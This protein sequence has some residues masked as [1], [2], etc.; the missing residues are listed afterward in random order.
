MAIEVFNRVEKKFLITKHQ[1]ELLK[2]YL[3]GY[4]EIDDYLKDK[5]TYSI[6]NIYYDTEDE[7]LIK[8]S[9][10]K[11]YFKEKLRIRGYG[12]VNLESMVY[13]EL[14]KKIHGIVNKRRSKIRLCEAYKFIA[15]GEMP[16][17]K[18]YH[19]TLVLK[20]I[21]QFLKRYSLRANT[22]IS[23]D[24]IAYRSGDFRVTIDKNIRSRK[25]NLRLEYGAY[26]L[27]LLDEGYM[28]LEAKAMGGFPIWFVEALSRLKIYQ[29]SFSKYG[30][31]FVRR[32]YNINE[33]GVVP[34]LNPYSVIQPQKISQC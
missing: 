25:D 32:H 8:Y 1:Y 21:A 23:Y 2:L 17:E 18:E 28:L 26:G 33:R 19:N 7:Y 12:K 13:I 27:P 34:C 6:N 10:S 5:D 16:D 4:M 15:T 24:R 9:L 29:T 11:P 22:A 31:D 30:K 14:K 20:E 3:D